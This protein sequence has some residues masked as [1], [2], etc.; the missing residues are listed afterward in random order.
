M[1]KYNFFVKF[2]FE[3]EADNEEEASK[4]ACLLYKQ[5]SRGYGRWQKWCK[6]LHEAPTDVTFRAEVR[7]NEI[8]PSN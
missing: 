6:L 3:L 4:A 5:H 2:S 7:G 1:T 8:D